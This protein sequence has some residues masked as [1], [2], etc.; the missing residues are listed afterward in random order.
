MLPVWRKAYWAYVALVWAAAVLTT[1]LA[2]ARADD[3]WGSPADLVLFLLL[4]VGSQFWQVRSIGTGFISAAFTVLFPSYL[5]LGPAGVLI[6]VM[7]NE[8]VFEALKGKRP[9]FKP[10]FSLGEFLLLGSLTNWLHGLWIAPHGGQGLGMF[11]VI[12]LGAAMSGLNI[13]LTNAAIA[14]S[15]GVTVWSAFTLHSLWLPFYFFMSVLLATLVYHLHSGLGF[16]GTLIG[17]LPV[18][19]FLLL[20]QNQARIRDS[21]L[22]RLLTQVSEI[23][24]TEKVLPNT[25]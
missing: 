14:L 10:A 8:F 18:A 20:M 15:I 25:D 22:N 24:E 12:L 23:D 4:S 16:W 11:G 19:F 13:L 6:I 17:I 3:L 7:V 2:F 9:L 21:Y 1:S 5:I